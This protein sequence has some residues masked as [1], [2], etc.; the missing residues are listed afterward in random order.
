MQ[1]MNLDLSLGL[2][3][4]TCGTESV[5]SGVEV[6]VGGVGV[7]WGEVEKLSR[8]AGGCTEGRGGWTKGD[9]GRFGNAEGKKV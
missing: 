5:Y 8:C 4:H 2:V 3:W 6:V 1:R 7:M 9:R